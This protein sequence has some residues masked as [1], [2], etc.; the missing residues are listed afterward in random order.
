MEKYFTGRENWRRWLRKNYKTSKEACVVHY[1]KASGKKGL[2]LHDGVNEAICFG[3]IDGKLK[4][5]DKDRFVV[6]Y[7]PRQKN[8][9]WSKINKD[10][11]EELIRQGK[12]TKAGLAAIEVAKASGAWDSAYTNKK[13]ESIPADLRKELLKD[14]TACENFKEFA[15]TYRNMYIGWIKGAKTAETRAKRIKEVVKKS[16]ENT[17]PG[18][19]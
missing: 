5:I 4:N 3:W 8:S 10:R 6:R 9:V 15:N 2:A 11:A 12:M 16:L 7:S 19:E 1:K 14:K 13:R 17:K 18:I